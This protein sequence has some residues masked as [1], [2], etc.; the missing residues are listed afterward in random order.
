MSDIVEIVDFSSSLAWHFSEL[1]LAWISKYFVV[2][3]DDETVLGNPKKYII[4][5]GGHIF[6]AKFHN[7]IVGTF[8]FMKEGNDV[9]KLSKMAVSENHLGKNIGNI[10]MKFGLKKAKELQA[11]KVILYS[12]MILGAA[13]HLYKKYGFVEVPLENPEF[14]RSNIK[15]EIDLTRQYDKD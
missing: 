14:E 8:A 9:F 3:P 11:K 2:E 4:D 5:E 7:E 1:N 10:M 13:I 6:F 12:N 15:M